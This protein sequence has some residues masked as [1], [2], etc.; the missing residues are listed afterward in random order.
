MFHSPY[1]SYC[2]FL[3]LLLSTIIVRKAIPSLFH[4]AMLLQFYLG[5]AKVVSVNKQ[6]NNDRLEGI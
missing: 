6:V 5:I 1:N 3:L 4:I 2:Y